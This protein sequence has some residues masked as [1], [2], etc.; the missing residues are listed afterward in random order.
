MQ[1]WTIYIH[2]GYNFCN[3][4]AMPYPLRSGQS[5]EDLHWIYKDDWKL[6]GQLNQKLKLRFLHPDFK[7]F[8]WDIENQMGGTFFTVNKD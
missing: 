4:Y 2:P 3:V 8:K 6:I 7:E 1:V 5:P